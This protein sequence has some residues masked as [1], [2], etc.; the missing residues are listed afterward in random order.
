MTAAESRVRPM[1]QATRHARTAGA[2]L[3]GTAPWTPEEDVEL[4]RC[5]ADDEREALV[6]RSSRAFHAVL[7]RRPWSRVQPSGTGWTS[8]P[9]TLVRPTRR[10]YVFWYEFTPRT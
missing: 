3:Q 9:R 7:Q 6:L 2:A 5:D 10:W 4:V 1:S 8:R